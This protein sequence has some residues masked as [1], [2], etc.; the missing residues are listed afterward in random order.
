MLQ[1]SQ[2]KWNYKQ[3][4]KIRSRRRQQHPFSPFSVEQVLDSDPYSTCA[5]KRDQHLLSVPCAQWSQ[6][7]LNWPPYGPL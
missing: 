3:E 4:Q 7:V 2:I 5:D 1:K 6:Q